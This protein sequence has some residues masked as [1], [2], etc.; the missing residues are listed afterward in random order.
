[1]VDHL[2]PPLAAT[3]LYDDLLELRQLIESAEAASDSSTRSRAV[4]TLRQ[5]I[6]EMDLREELIAS[7]DEELTVR[8]VGF[9]EVDEEFLL[10][11]VGHYLTSLQE[12][13]M[14]LGLHVFGRDWPEESLVTMLTSMSD[15]NS[16]KEQ[17]AMWRE[18]LAR[19]PAAE[20]QALLA[21]LS[22]PPVATSTRWTAVCSQRGWAMPRAASLRTLYCRASLWISRPWCPA[23]VTSKGLFSG[24]LMQCATRAR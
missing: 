11:E 12:A 14:P 24:R 15:D 16:S 7:M 17:L 18:N 2:T 8:G 5:R 4:A 10:H 23:K 22:G 13:F 21:G 1:M 19:S 20:M 6:E 3:E 9:D